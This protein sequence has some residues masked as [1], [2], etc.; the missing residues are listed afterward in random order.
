MGSA[1]AGRWLL[2]LLVA[3]WWVLMACASPVARLLAGLVELLGAALAA[4]WCCGVWPWQRPPHACPVLE[5]PARGRRHWHCSRRGAALCRWAAARRGAQ[6][7]QPSRPRAWRRR[8]LRA[9]PRL[10]LAIC[11]LLVFALLLAE[12]RT[13]ELAVWSEVHR[14]ESP[15]WGEQQTTASLGLLLTSLCSGAAT[16]LHSG[17]WALFIAMLSG[18]CVLCLL[19][20]V[21]AVVRRTAASPCL[22][23]LFLLAECCSEAHEGSLLPALQVW[24]ALAMG[25]AAVW[26]HR[27]VGTRGWGL[28]CRAAWGRSLHSRTASRSHPTDAEIVGGHGCA[29]C[30]EQG[31]EVG[32]DG[33]VSE[34]SECSD[35]EELQ[36]TAPLE[37]L[38]REATAEEQAAFLEAQ[39]RAAAQQ[40]EEAEELLLDPP[41]PDS[42]MKCPVGQE[43]G[44]EDGPPALAEDSSSSEDG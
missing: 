18:T 22:L 14:L 39:A 17:A 24:G 43:S 8:R 26:M 27:L 31:R 5:L 3:S 20:A 29:N 16:S 34:C 40:E 37:P 33:D 4:A 13:T 21:S 44:D 1:S 25:C 41:L 7:P 12:L 23:L 32:H 9:R 42:S 11:L 2:P 6:S 10:H 15:L 36:P 30:C 28:W 35:S 19:L 38:L